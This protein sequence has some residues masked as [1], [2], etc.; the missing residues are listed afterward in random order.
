MR[1][2]NVTLEPG[3]E[4]VRCHQC[5][6]KS[7]GSW[8]FVCYRKGDVKKTTRG[9]S[10]YDGEHSP[11][12]Y[13]WDVW[14]VTCPECGNWVTIRESEERSTLYGVKPGKRR[15]RKRR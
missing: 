8:V 7:P 12:E 2:I 14:Y 13:E 1:C 6:K 3:E 10:G 5:E 11:Y 4:S 9:R 15:K